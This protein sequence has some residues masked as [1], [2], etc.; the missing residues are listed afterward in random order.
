[1]WPSKQTLHK[2]KQAQKS[3]KREKSACAPV[4]VRWSRLSKKEKMI[5]KIALAVFLIGVAVALGVGISVAVKGA[6]Y[7]SNGASK[8]VGA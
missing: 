8:T 5:S 4:A 3:R 7:V 2:Q 1:M 6:Y